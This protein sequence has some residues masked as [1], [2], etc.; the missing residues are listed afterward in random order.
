MRYSTGPVITDNFVDNQSNEVPLG[1]APPEII[2]EQLMRKNPDAMTAMLESI[3]I[4]EEDFAKRVE[5]R[6]K[7][8]T[9]A[10]KRDEE[11]E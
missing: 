11:K 8:E 7:R 10:L 9:A 3:G 5:D 1:E 2:L 6:I 4:T